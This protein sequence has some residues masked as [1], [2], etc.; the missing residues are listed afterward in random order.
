MLVTEMLV[1]VNKKLICLRLLTLL[2]HPC[3][4]LSAHLVKYNYGT[5]FSDALALLFTHRNNNIMNVVLVMARFDHRLRLAK[6]T[7][8]LFRSFKTNAKL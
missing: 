5:R 1:A 2:A 7:F 6:E 8:N 4:R 3:T